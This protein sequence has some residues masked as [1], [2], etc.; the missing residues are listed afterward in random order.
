MNRAL[1]ISVSDSQ[2][3]T[4]PPSA[5]DAL[6]AYGYGEKEMALKRLGILQ[7]G[8]SQSGHKI[9]LISTTTPKVIVD[10][11]CSNASMNEDLPIP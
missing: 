3:I 1:Q 10:C 9:L 8:I 2:R 6:I 4:I 11:V 7:F 5:L